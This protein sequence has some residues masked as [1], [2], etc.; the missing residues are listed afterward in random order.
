MEDYL[1]TSRIIMA[2]AVRRETNPIIVSVQISIIHTTSCVGV[3]VPA[4]VPAAVLLRPGR[5]GARQRPPSQSICQ[6]GSQLSSLLLFTAGSDCLFRSCL[7]S[8]IMA[9]NHED[10][11]HDVHFES[12]DAGSSTTFPAQAGSIRKGGHI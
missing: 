4:G 10:H 6:Q 7:F 1:R 2:V 8:F 12:T 11:G 5:A 3:S 9:D